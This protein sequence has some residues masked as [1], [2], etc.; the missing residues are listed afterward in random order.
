M[1]I[2][3]SLFFIASLIPA[4]FGSTEEYLIQVNGELQPIPC[5]PQAE[6]K[7]YY[8]FSFPALVSGFD[9]A[10]SFKFL[11]DEPNDY[12]Y[13][14]CDVELSLEES[15]QQIYCYVLAYFFPLFDSTKISVPS[16]LNI[17]DNNFVR[18]EGWKGGQVDIGSACYIQHAYEF[19]HTHHPE[20][21]FNMKFDV[22]VSNPPYQL[23]TG[24]GT[25][26][27]K[28]A[29]QAKPIYHKFIEQA[30]KL[31]EFLEIEFDVMFFN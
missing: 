29:T 13:V 12:M 14:T 27:K 31:C 9:K 8:G 22:I 19:I 5:S 10:V 1:K 2:I 21:I 16:L 15:S 6:G 20:E 3:Y 24:G 17:L 25:G 18:I 28:S 11:L 23:E 30:K 7:T 4:I 26:E